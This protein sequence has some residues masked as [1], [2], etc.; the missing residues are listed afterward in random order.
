M[1]RGIVEGDGA[2]VSGGEE[3]VED[4]RVAARLSMKLPEATL[5]A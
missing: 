4:D 1:L 5:L 3:T 2:I